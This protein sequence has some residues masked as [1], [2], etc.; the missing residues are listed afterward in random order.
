ME[1]LLSG[2]AARHRLMLVDTCAA[3]ETD[4]DEVARQ[5]GA[6]KLAPG[7]QVASRGLKRKQSAQ[8]PT[9]RDQLLLTRE[10]FAG[11]RRGSGA[12][13]I[14]SSSGVEYAFESAEIKNGVFTSALLETLDGDLGDLERENVSLFDDMSPAS[15]EGAVRVKV[16][17]RTGG[18]QHPVAREINLDD[19][20]IVWL[21]PGRKTWK[22]HHPVPRGAPKSARN[23]ARK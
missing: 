1:G 15:I 2:L 14:G 20:F 10:L 7:V 18:L 23:K 21:Q 8:A 19:P 9:A 6:D 12:S 11:L 5:G 17:A 16:E 13:V 22:N 3:G 4:E